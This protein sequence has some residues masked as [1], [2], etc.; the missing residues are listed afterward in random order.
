MKVPKY[1]QIAIKRYLYHRKVEQNNSLII[2]KFV[3]KSNIDKNTS[4]KTL[5]DKS[6]FDEKCN[7]PQGQMS[8]YDL[9]N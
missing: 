4:L 9:L 8:I 2:K 5:V 7:I 3:D 6:L 1:V